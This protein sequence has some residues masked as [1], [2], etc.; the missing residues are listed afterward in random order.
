MLKRNIS[1]LAFLLVSSYLFL[2]SPALA[3]GNWDNGRCIAPGTDVATL[4]GLEC[5]FANILS[6]IVLIAGLAF[7][8]MFI[9][10]G[11]QYLFSSDDSKQVAAATGTLTSAI[12]GL[13]GVIGS[14]FI[15]RLIE[16]FTGINITTFIIPG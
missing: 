16:N 10:G 3:Q 11:F 14:W 5:L 13:V 2:V 7:M 6:V 12:I 8:A 9:V 4:Q 15:L 1:A